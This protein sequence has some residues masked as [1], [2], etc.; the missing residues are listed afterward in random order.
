MLKL[1]KARKISINVLELAAIVIIFFTT[2]LHFK[3]NLTKGGCHPKVYCQGD[4]SASVSWYNKFSN[5][6]PHAR[7]L[8]K[9]LAMGQKYTDLDMDMT[10]LAGSEN[11]FADAI[12]R[13]PPETTLNP[14]FKQKVSSNTA[15]LSSLQVP[16]STKQIYCRRYQPSKEVKS[17]ICSALLLQDTSSLPM[18][19]KNNIGQLKHEQSIT[20]NFAQRNWNWTLN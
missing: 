13:G 10:W 15:A 14:L 2:A 4:N 18:L 3:L 5:P 11:H 6:E 19:N 12:S 9:I 17:W 7:R 16:L 20:L 8:T 1:I